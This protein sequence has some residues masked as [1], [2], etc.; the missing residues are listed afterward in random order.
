MGV[1]QTDDECLQHDYII[2]ATVSNIVYIEILALSNYSG[3]SNWQYFE[4]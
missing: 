2:Y 1:R 3:F 4:Y